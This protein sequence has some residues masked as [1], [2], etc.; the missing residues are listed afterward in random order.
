MGI[1]EKRLIPQAQ[2]LN[3]GPGPKTA[4]SGRAG[5]S[6]PTRRLNRA[7]PSGGHSQDGNPAIQASDSGQHGIYPPPSSCDRSMPHR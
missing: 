6:N 1:L 5:Y 3:L 7:D 4:P 2:L